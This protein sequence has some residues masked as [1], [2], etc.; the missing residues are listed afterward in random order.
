MRSREIAPGMLE[1]TSRSDWPM[2]WHGLR[3][4][5][6]IRA[7]FGQ[8]LRW[9]AALE[10]IR[11]YYDVPDEFRR[12]AL[13]TF[14]DGRGA[15][16]RFV[17]MASVCCRR[18]QGRRTAASTKNW[19]ADDLSVRDRAR[20]PL[21]RWMIAGSCIAR[22]R[23]D[24]RDSVAAEA[25]G[26]DRGDRSE[27]CLIGQPV[28][29]RLRGPHPI[30]ALRICAALASSRETWSADADTAHAQF[31]ACTWPVSA[32]RCE[33]RVAAAAYRWPEFRGSF[34][35]ALESDA[36]GATSRAIPAPTGSDSPDSRRWRS[37][38]P[39]FGRCATN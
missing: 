2:Q 25:H 36:S 38:G 11:A 28:A 27:P 6:P 12:M 37:A 34:R 15:H 10:E 31:T 29:F 19:R 9:E 22:L 18:S 21:S 30:A 32:P 1:Y 26:R 13:T 5:F 39:T 14:G 3:S 4:R 24:A 16:H 7:N 8:W 23:V 33:A 17:A 20:D 35:V